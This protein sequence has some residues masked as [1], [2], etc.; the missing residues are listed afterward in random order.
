MD[1][2]IDED[3][4]I[5]AAFTSSG[6][7]PYDGTPNLFSV[8]TGGGRDVTLTLPDG[9]RATFLFTPAFRVVGGVSLAYA[10]WQSPPG[11]TAKLTMI[12]LNPSGANEINFY[13]N[14]FGKP[15]W[16][17]GAYTT[18]FEAYDIPGYY[19]TM[20]DGTIYELHRDPAFP[21]APEVTWDSGGGSGLYLPVTPYSGKPNCF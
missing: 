9:R 14:G 15:V 8:R 19:L 18:P 1:A 20:K 2:V 13:Q 4:Q 5:T 17:S 11:V 6:D 12:P 21:G 3:R 16:S 7:D 10:E